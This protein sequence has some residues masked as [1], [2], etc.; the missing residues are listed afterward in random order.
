MARKLRVV[1]DYSA[2]TAEVEKMSGG[3]AV[4]SAE[5][6]ER[7]RG[8]QQSGNRPPSHDGPMIREEEIPRFKEMGYEVATVD[9]HPV[10]WNEMWGMTAPEEIREAKRR[11]GP[12]GAKAMLES[13]K[14]ARPA[15]KNV[16]PGFDVTTEAKIVDSGVTIR[17]KKEE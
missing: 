10:R 2:K 9:G 8:I 15:T 11:L 6:V 13:I 1:Q 16:L 5:L 17:Q 14:S 12:T 4:A 7:I 3:T